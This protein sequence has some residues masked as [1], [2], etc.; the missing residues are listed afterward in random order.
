MDENVAWSSEPSSLRRISPTGFL[1]KK[2]P[3]RI[4]RKLINAGQKVL[5]VR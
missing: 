3:D 4:S 1:L 5:F 2:K